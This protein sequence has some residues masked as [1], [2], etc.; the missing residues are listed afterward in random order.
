MDMNPIRRGSGNQYLHRKTALYRQH[1]HRKIRA[2]HVYIQ[3]A[4]I[5]QG[6][7]LNL[8]VNHGPLVWD[9]FRSWLRTMNPL[10]PPSELVVAH[11]LRS[12]LPEFLAS[13]SAD[14]NLTKFL[15]TY[16]DHKQAGARR[17]PAA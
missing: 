1:V 2:Y 16:Q 11:A 8:A 13:P 3:L 4:C 14:H 6:I 5:T 9:R 17:R 12:E 7:L 15:D 10:Q